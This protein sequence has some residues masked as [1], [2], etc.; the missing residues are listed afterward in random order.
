MSGPEL[1]P[2]L[3]HDT[4][5]DIRPV[6]NVQTFRPS[7]VFGKV[8]LTSHRAV[9]ITVHILMVEKGN[10][11][12]YLPTGIG[13]YTLLQWH[14]VSVPPAEKNGVALSSAYLIRTLG[15]AV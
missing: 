7:S 9:N 14:V 15:I 10:I 8:T 11:M 1:E 4:P 13:L 6:A 2:E 12:N 3:G 5:L